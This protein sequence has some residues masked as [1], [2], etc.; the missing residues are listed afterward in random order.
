MQILVYHPRQTGDVIIGS[1]CA[2]LLK[3]KHPDATIIFVTD[4]RLVP[5]IEPCPWLDV[6]VDEP[7]FEPKE[8]LKPEDKHKRYMHWEWNDLLN[9]RAFEKM[10]NDWKPD[11]AYKPRWNP[12]EKPIPY[13]APYMFRCYA[14]CCGLTQEEA[15][16]TAYSLPLDENERDV[17]EGIWN[18][19]TQFTRLALHMDHLDPSFL[20][21]VDRYGALV[22]DTSGK[23]SLRE[24]LAI[25]AQADCVVTR[26]GGVAVMAASVDTPTVMVP[27]PEPST[28]ASPEFSHPNCGHIVVKPIR[29]CNAYEA[30]DE[31]RLQPCQPQ[32]G[33][34]FEDRCVLGLK[35]RD[36]VADGFH[37]WRSVKV[38]DLYPH[39][40]LR[41]E[42]T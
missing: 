15:N 28:W 12:M 18:H 20:A 39:I 7:E 42:Y 8:I 26:Y 40:E 29:T 1:H 11:L 23:V 24:N 13:K 6:V 41:L 27:K 9:V 22:L 30:T 17:A 3:K 35:G 33:E 38:E 16:D 14:H 19:H 5:L 36:D 31:H 32:Y 21:L 37:C 25:L 34:Y 4:K 2:R 10:V